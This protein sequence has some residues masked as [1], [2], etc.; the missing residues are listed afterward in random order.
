NTVRQARTDFFETDN[1]CNIFGNGCDLRLI[2]QLPPDTATIQN[3]ANAIANSLVTGGTNPTIAVNAI[4]LG[5][6]RVEGLL[7]NHLKITTL[8][9]G[10]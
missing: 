6:A 1:N 7:V 2:A 9:A 5:T 8:G 10:N 3:R 4:N